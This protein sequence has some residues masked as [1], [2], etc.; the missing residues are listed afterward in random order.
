MSI[1]TILFCEVSPFTNKFD[2][3]F[4]IGAYI[5]HC[6]VYNFLVTLFSEV[7]LRTWSKLSSVYLVLEIGP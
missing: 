4:I 3:E 1:L 7:G 5:T 2:L 6:V